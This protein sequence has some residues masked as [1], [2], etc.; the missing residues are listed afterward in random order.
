MVCWGKFSCVREGNSVKYNMMNNDEIILL[1]CVCLKEMCLF[2][3]MIQQQFVDCVY[4]GIVIIKCIEKGGGF[5]F[6]MLI[7]F[8]WVLDKLY[9]FDVVLFEFELCNFYES[10]EGGEGSGCFQVCQQVVDL[11]NKFFVLQLEE[12]NYS[13][14]LENLLCW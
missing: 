7:F 1:L 3:L 13:V 4:V 12:V 9:N 6:D 11:N 14:V 8:L 10:Y 5:N 2:F